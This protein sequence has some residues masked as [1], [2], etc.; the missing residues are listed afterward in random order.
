MKRDPVVRYMMWLLFI[1]VAANPPPRDGTNHYAAA[2][3]S[4]LVMMTAY[5]AHGHFSHQLVL[6]QVSGWLQREGEGKGVD[7]ASRGIPRKCCW[8]IGCRASQ[9]PLLHPFQSLRFPVSLLWQNK[10]VK[11][12]GSCEDS[13]GRFLGGKVF[14]K[15]LLGNLFCFDLCYWC[16]NRKAKKCKIL[17][18]PRQYNEIVL[19]LLLQIFLKSIIFH[20]VL[21]K[22]LLLHWTNFIATR[23][24]LIPYINTSSSLA[25][26]ESSGFLA[27]HL[28]GNA[29]CQPWW[30]PVIHK[31]IFP[32][33]KGNVGPSRASQWAPKVQW[34]E[35]WGHC[36][37]QFGLCG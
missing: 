14:L 36:L 20:R 6:Q 19:R 33:L 5:L 8:R 34:E 18:N 37:C 4:C 22:S 7:R 32:S 3:R 28:V 35:I 30:G 10:G 13:L 31:G 25:A 21:R 17:W 26:T 16:P 9:F 1:N 23:K 15:M 12:L 29:P 2:H 27:A 24:H 11:V